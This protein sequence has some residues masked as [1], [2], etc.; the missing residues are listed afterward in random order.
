[1]Y[2]SY[3]D[4]TVPYKIYVNRSLHLQTAANRTVREWGHRTYS[5]PAER[6]QTNYPLIP[7][8]F[9]T[10]FLI[11]DRKHMPVTSQI[12]QNTKIDLNISK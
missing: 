3:N 1:M 8:V 5:D 9:R 10:F 12:T 6:G 11:T 4:V 2:D 7:T